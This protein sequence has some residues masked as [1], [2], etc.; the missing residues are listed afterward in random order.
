MTESNNT[1]MEKMVKRLADLEERL[2]AAEARADAAEA[3][4]DAA[5][6]RAAAAEERAAAAEARAAAA[7]ARVAE[8][9]SLVV[10]LEARANAAEE[11]L[12]NVSIAID[13]L[14]ITGRYEYWDWLQEVM[15]M[16]LDVAC[17][18]LP[19]ILPSTCSQA[20]NHY[21]HIL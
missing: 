10:E 17:P 2:A 16:P 7:E 3:R 15:D 14:C 21:S 13:N 18:P 5:E 1:E 9:E 4:A 6:A 19:M 12:C 11:R 20:Y 8:L